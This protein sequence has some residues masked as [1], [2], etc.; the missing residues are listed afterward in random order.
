V[1]TVPARIALAAAVIPLAAGLAACGSESPPTV[2]V[3]AATGSA[4]A[5]A[6]GAS[7]Q[8][9]PFLEVIG[10]RIPVPPARA[11]QAQVDMTLVNSNT[12]GSAELTRVSSTLARSVEFT[13]DGRAVA[14]ITIPTS[15]GFAVPVGPPNPYRVLL[16]G[17][18]GTLHTGQ[19]VA[20]SLTF[21]P[22]GH[23]TLRVPVVPE[24]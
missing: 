5:N 20:L 22:D 13:R 18:R 14:A 7:T 16:T 3:P 6:Q 8:V 4:T 15:A 12:S 19:F 17:L 24:P 2:S 21:G 9:G 10:A 1:R 11:G 23:T